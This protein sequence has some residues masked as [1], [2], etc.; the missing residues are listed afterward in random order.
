ML[1]AIKG[2][3]LLGI[4]TTMD[5]P[6]LPMKCWLAHWWDQTARDPCHVH[7]PVLS[8][9]EPQRAGTL[10]IPW[11]STGTGHC[12]QHPDI[13]CKGAQALLT[14]SCWWAASQR[15]QT[16]LGCCACSEHTPGPCAS[17]ALER[18]AG[19]PIEPGL[20]TGTCTLQKKI[21]AGPD[22]SLPRKAPSG[23]PGTARSCHQAQAAQLQLLALW[24][25]RGWGIFWHVPKVL[26]QL[27]GW[28]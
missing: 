4:F 27:W 26:L 9:L 10:L 15:A 25:N 19:I 18:M 16:T 23:A 24:K 14:L 13:C 11:P 22:L 5:I 2:Q 20:F 28:R 6:K 8:P 1:P 21:G 7:I 12:L 3:R 17:K